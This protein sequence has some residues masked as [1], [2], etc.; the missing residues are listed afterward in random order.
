[1]RAGGETY[2]KRNE[3]NLL[4]ACLDYLKCLE[5]QKKIL[6]VD[7]LNSGFIFTGRRRIRLC[8]AGTPDAY[9]ITATGGLIWI[10]TKFSTDLNDNQKE[11]RSVV[12]RAGHDYWV[13]RDIDELRVK[14]RYIENPV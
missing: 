10:E 12:E 9:M 7:R 11:F 4:T 2:K 5:N 8:R 1:M 6:W 13:I 14:L 3:S